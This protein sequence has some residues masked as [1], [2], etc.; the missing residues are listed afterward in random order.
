MLSTSE[1]KGMDGA[2]PL[3]IPSLALGIFD[4]DTEAKPK[5]NFEQTPGFSPEKLIG[6]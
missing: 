3:S 1:P 2:W 6:D 5:Y 4:K